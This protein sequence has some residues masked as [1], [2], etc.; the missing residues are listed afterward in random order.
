MRTP[1][2]YL[3]KRQKC[4][5]CK[6]DSFNYVRKHNCETCA[7]NGWRHEGIEEAWEGYKYGYTRPDDCT[8]DRECEE[9]SEC[10]LGSNANSGCMILV[11]AKCGR[12]HEHI[13]MGCD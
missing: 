8:E 6:H 7:N 2:L 10:L 9:N 1:D 5:H 11:C 3:D 4:R 12:L 13:E